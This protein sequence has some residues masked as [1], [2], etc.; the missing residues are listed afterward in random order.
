MEWLQQTAILG[1]I[2]IS[3]ALFVMGVLSRR[4]GRV[5]HARPYYLGFFVAAALV[6]AASMV[7]LLTLQTMT[8]VHDTQQV[9]DW[10]LIYNGLLASGITL[11]L[12]VGWYYWSWLLAERD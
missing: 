6:A 8:T 12:L 3:F 5:T 1:P 2:S 11:G 10:T 9:A 7:R 4:L